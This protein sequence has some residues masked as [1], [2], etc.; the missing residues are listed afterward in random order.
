MKLKKLKAGL[1]IMAVGAFTV[2]CEKEYEEEIT[3]NSQDQYL[4]VDLP[5]LNADRQK[6]NLP[7]INENL[8]DYILGKNA[9]EPSECAPTEFA[10]VQDV[11]LNPLI[12]DLYS[13]F[14][15]AQYA[16]IF[17]LYMDL[18]FYSAY[19]DTSTDQYFGENG[20]YTQLVT[21]RQRELEKFWDMPNEVRINGQHTATL[22]DREK[23]ADVYEIVGTGITTREQ[24]YA[25]ADQILYFNTFSDQLPDNP[26]FA[27]D[28]FATSANL[29]VIGDGIVQM[30]AEAG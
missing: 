1:L 27:I 8:T 12:N 18:N 25:A 28:G 17:Y 2:S 22:N 3:P 10:A 26:F 13:L 15:Q 16:N 5:Q 6:S 9:V 20:N 29:I 30:L 4:Q 21:K 7:E 11:Y 23:L 24:A 14:G 19:F